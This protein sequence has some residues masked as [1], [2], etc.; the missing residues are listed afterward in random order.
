[1][2]RTQNRLTIKVA[3]NWNKQKTSRQKTS[4]EMCTAAGTTKTRNFG[5]RHSI[6]EHFYMLK[7]SLGIEYTRSGVAARPGQSNK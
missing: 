4:S 2:Y 1:M 7:I 5:K 3:L 6:Y